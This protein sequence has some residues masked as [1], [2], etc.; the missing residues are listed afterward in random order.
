MAATIIEETEDN[1]ETSPVPTDDNALSQD[2]LVESFSPA[3]T[4]VLDTAPEDEV[5]A[6]Y[7]GKSIVEVVAMHQ[8]AEK[9]IGTQGSEVGDLRKVVDDFITSQPVT[10]SQP[11]VAEEP[12]DF[13][14]DP[15]KAVSRA[16]DSH[17]DV[18]RAKQ[19]SVDMQRNSSVSQLQAKHPDM[20]QVLKNPAF[21]EWVKGSP[22]RRELFGRADQQYDFD[23]ADELI[24]NFKERTAVVQATVQTETAARQQAVRQASTGS[25][26]GA[27]TSGSK[28]IYRRA[29]I[30]KL[31]KTDP[32]RYE[33]INPEIM[34]AYQ[35]GRVK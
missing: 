28:R 26:S 14:E 27:N 4:T 7:K 16:I 15:E 31:M 11:F 21:V 29:D 10:P 8:A 32:D 9:L 30:I 23:S 6:K 2:A 1:V 19:A 33:A 34:L 17:P 25:A 5:P 20:E 13:F 12:I 3:D 24:S 22:V 18:V 35:E